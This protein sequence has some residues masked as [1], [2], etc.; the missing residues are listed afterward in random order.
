MTKLNKLVRNVLRY[1]SE[2]NFEDIR[3]LLEEFDFREVRSSSSH[4]I[5]RHRD[6]RIQSIPKK[7]GR[8]VKEVYIKKIVKQLNLEDWYY[9]QE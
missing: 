2:L 1:P 4:V 3:H 9:D 7:N 5:F 8:K 6:G